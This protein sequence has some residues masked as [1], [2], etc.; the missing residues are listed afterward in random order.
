MSSCNPDRAHDDTEDILCTWECVIKSVD[1][2]R[3]L[4]LGRFLSQG[5]GRVLASN[6]GW[7]QKAQQ[8]MHLDCVLYSML[9]RSGGGI[10]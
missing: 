4:V 5:S 8:W 6:G 2:L 10:C 3:G 7:D 1:A 9:L